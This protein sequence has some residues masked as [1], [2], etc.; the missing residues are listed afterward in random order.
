LKY[1]FCTS[2][3]IEGVNTSAKN[4]IYYDNHKGL[5]ING[6]PKN[7]DFFDYS[8]I[9]GRAGRMM[10]H[11]IGVIYNFNKPPVDEQIIVDIPFFQQNPIRDEVL[12]QMN[13]DELL[14][15][16]SPQNININQIPEV[17]REVIKR[18]GVKVHGQKSIID[19]LRSEIKTNYDLISWSGKPK[20]EQLKYVL[21]LAWNNLIVEGE[22]TRPMSLDKLAKMTFDY[23]IE[24][25]VNTIIRNDFLY[26]RKQPKFKDISDS[27]L[28][29]LSIQETFQIMKHWFEYKIPKWLSV[30]NELQKFVCS[31]FGFRPGNYTFYANLI[32]NDFLR[33]NLAILAEYGIP[34]SAIRKIENKIPININQ[35]NVLNY[36]RDNRIVFTKGLLEYEKQ[37]IKDN[38]LVQ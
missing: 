2:T 22:T 18:N 3:I 14:D 11:F 24:Q 34:A 31:E 25:N 7:V 8:N 10:E 27:D 15:P 28:R 30:I 37:K 29:D 12:I 5:N 17:E 16:H 33:E 1:L 19:I 23:G 26:K 6:T 36:I 35:D 13:D 38:I 4:I 9:K 32:E 20:Y 21:F